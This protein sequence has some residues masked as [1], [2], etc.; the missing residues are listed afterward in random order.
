MLYPVGTYVYLHEVEKKNKV[1]V[2]D[3]PWVPKEELIWYVS[4]GSNMLLE[5]FR[6]YLEGGSFRG[7]GR[8]QK[9]CTDRRLPRRKKKVTIPFEAPEK[10]SIWLN[11]VEPQK[12]MNIIVVVNMVLAKD[13]LKIRHVMLL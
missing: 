8:H 7:L 4:Y 13:A 3:Q 10:E 2:T 9:E 5:R 1:A 11:A 12:I 6:Y